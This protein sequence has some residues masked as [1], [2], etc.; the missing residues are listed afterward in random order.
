VSTVRKQVRKNLLTILK[1][2]TKAKNCVFANRTRVNWQENLPAINLY[3]R[4]EPTIEEVSQAPREIKRNLQLEVE[5]VV[6]GKDENEASDCLDDL[7]EEVETL[8]AID[9]SIGGCVSDIVQTSVTDIE[10]VSEGSKDTMATK[11]V[12]R[13]EY[14]TYAPRE[15]SQGVLPDFKTLTGEWDL[16]P[17]QEVGDRANDTVTVQQP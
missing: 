9:D 7:C 12:Y 15:G 6:D 3:F 1:G 8:L 17:G 13:I 4:G 14:V 5:I 16:Q 2:R 11:L 10:G